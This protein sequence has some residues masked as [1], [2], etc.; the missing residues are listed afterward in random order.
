MIPRTVSGHLW[1]YDGKRGSTFYAKLRI[2][3]RK[4]TVRIGPLWT[5]K[6][7]PPDG[8]YTQRTAQS[9]LQAMLIDARR[10]NLPGFIR[11]GHTFR[12][13]AEAWFEWGETEREWKPSTQR[14]YRSALDA[15][16][17]PGLGDYRLEEIT[18]RTIEQWRA[19]AMAKP[20]GKGRLS[21][22]MAAKCLAM[23]HSIFERARR[24]HDL[25]A[26]P[27]AD[28]EPLRQRYD[29]ARFSF[30]SP[31]Q[32][33]ALVRAAASK[34]DGAIFLTAAFTGLRMGELLALRVRDVDFEQSAIRV[35]G[36]VD[37]IAGVGLPKSGHGRSV[38]LVD[39]VAQALAQL[40][41]RD[42]FTGPDD[43][44]FVGD[45][46]RWLDGSALRGRF[47]AAATKAGLPP[48]RFHDLRH[49]FGS[50]AI[51][52]GSLIDVQHWLGHADSRTTSRYL[53]YA[54]RA[55]EA[56]LLAGA[57][58]VEQPDVAETEEE[59]EA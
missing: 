45:T 34:Q 33:H 39:Q 5:G 46:G 38:P 37:S 1:R 58:A 18:S 55:N 4:K 28:V 47:K 22:R 17:L 57:F 11:T 41:Q 51:T 36:S 40:L 52:R 43:F 48:L 6:G 25:P 12:D 29:R 35:L 30:Y 54:S 44:V 15:H 14:D 8:Y 27:A 20:K 26:N 31:E 23:T 7:R 13:A 49:T 10:G 3:N 53:H 21:K 19:E 42:M 59:T 56:A 9:A 2:D 24:Q 16:L 32:V 50:L